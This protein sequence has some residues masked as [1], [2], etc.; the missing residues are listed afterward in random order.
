[1]DDQGPGNA[2]LIID[3]EIHE[4]ALID[5]D[6]SDYNCFPVFELMEPYVIGLEIITHATRLLLDICGHEEE[7]TMP[8]AR[9][10]HMDCHVILGISW[11]QRHEF[12]LQQ[13]FEFEYS[14]VEVGTEKIFAPKTAEDLA[15]M[16]ITSTECNSGFADPE[17]PGSPESR[18]ASGQL[19][20]NPDQ[21]TIVKHELEGFSHIV[22]V[23]SVLA[24]MDDCSLCQD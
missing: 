10:S 18:S 1:M 9:L 13:N 11:L 5:R 15:L 7:V 23:P 12:C 21:G 2:N 16:N 8:V 17:N 22:N 24:G 20:K 3:H 4:Y 6:F 14:L 19:D